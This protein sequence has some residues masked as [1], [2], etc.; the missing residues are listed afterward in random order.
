MK[1]LATLISLIYFYLNVCYA[2]VG[3][4]LNGTFY[5]AGT[6]AVILCGQQS[7]S[8]KIK[9]GA[10]YRFC[11]SVITQPTGWTVQ[12]NDS[13]GGCPVFA[14]TYS[15]G[16]T[17][18]ME[19][20]TDLSGRTS[21]VS[22][23]VERPIPNNFDIIGYSNVCSGEVKIF[24]LNNPPSGTITWSTGSN[25]SLGSNGNTSTQVSTTGNGSSFVG[26]TINTT[27]GCGVVTRSKIVYAGAPTLQVMTYGTQGSGVTNTVN[28]VNT[29]SPYTWYIVRT[30]ENDG[31][32]NWTVNNSING[33]VSSTYEYRFN[34]SSGQNFT[35]FPISASNSCG[36]ASRYPTFTTTSGYSLASNPASSSLQIN[37]DN[38]EII[39]ALP[40]QID[41]YSES[42]KKPVRSIKIKDIF[43]K[44]AF[45]NNKSIVL[46]V[47]DLTRGTYYLHVIN[48]K[49]KEHTVDAIRVILH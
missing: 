39:E 26:V 42:I 34:L 40:D 20:L 33:Y 24:S 22:I 6:T 45:L 30:N 44:K 7:V 17:L 36:S 3:I 16:G 15:T 28:T 46:D 13:Q 48:Y 49:N 27:N 11:N 2:Q 10:I 21:Q 19:Y 5:A 29:V 12:N 9:D 23:T 41:L 4:E 8:V 1:T 35:F 32:V 25:L 18:T 37:F 43:D 14:A 38:T 47:E 31:T